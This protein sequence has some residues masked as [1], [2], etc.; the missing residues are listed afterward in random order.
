MEK[1][2]I[3]TGAT[4]GLGLETAKKI[5]G[6]SEEFHLVLPCRNKE[7]G[8]AVRQ[9]LV[10]ESGNKNIDMESLDTSSLKSVR[11]F[12]DTYKEKYGKK[13][14]ALLCNAG[15]SGMG[16]D[17][18]ELTPEGFDI[19]FATNHL[20]HFLLTN[21]LLPFMAE[22][23]KIIATSS[24]MH[25]PMLQEGETFEWLGTEAIAHPGDKIA[26]SPLRYSYSKLCNLY[27]IYELAR[28]LKEKNSTVTANAFNPGLMR[29]H[30]VKGGANEKLFEYIRK[31]VPERY[32]DLGN[33]SSALAELAYSDDIIFTSGHFY[34]RSTR[35]CFTS[36]LSYNKENAAELWKKSAEYCGLK[37][38]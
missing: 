31:N 9:Q 19:V 8:E 12:A 29:T 32:G 1:I 6:H 36:E 16:H 10:D 24:D 3:I 22:G 15:I 7:K 17:K 27:F 5:A 14:Y 2:V 4:S 18:P 30:L 33:S 21:L 28:K 23:G 38:N 26:V 35:P 13:I 11:E 37:E 25:N 34:D 20:G